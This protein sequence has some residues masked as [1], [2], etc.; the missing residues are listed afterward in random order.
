MTNAQFAKF[1]KATG[2][3]TLA[4]RGSILRR[5]RNEPCMLAPGSVM[6]IPPTELVAAA[7]ARNG[8]NMS[9]A[10]TG[11]HPEGPGSSIKGRR[12]IPW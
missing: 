9:M 11:A 3:V 10:R 12:T 5:I 7:T 8:G 6:F 1:V 4:E 2:Y